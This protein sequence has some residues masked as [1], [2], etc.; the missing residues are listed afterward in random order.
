[1]RYAVKKFKTLGLCLRELQPF[2]QDGQHLLTGKPFVKFDGL[3][4]RELL[5]NWL[6]CVAIN[7]ITQTDRLTFSSDPTGGD[8]V[9][10][11]TI[12]EETWPVEHVMIP[13]VTHGASAEIHDLIVAAV[14][15]KQQKGG[16]AYA[17]GKTL[18]VFLNAGSGE[19]HPNKVARALPAPLLFEAVWVWGFQSHDEGNY[20]Y[21]VT[22][23]DIRNGNAP[24]WRVRISADFETW[25]I[26]VVQ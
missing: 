20:T 11:D 15:S 24:A 10:V 5:G 21:N 16:A 9:I 22:R 3:R 1:M 6:C 7:S 18:I 12:T 8:G 19:W 17:T 4:S 2:I 14:E 26:E 23:L 25:A 13:A